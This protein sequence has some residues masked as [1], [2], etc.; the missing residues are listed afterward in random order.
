MTPLQILIYV[1]FNCS[2]YKYK[3]TDILRIKASI[4][5]IKNYTFEM[6]YLTVV[7]I[8]LKK[9]TTIALG[10]KYLQVAIF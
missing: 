9:V 7:E 5:C 4:Y 8:V 1:Y 3:N 10:L 6:Y 2:F